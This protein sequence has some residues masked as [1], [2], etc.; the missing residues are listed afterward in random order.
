MRAIKILHLILLIA[1]LAACKV[2]FNYQ[3]APEVPEEAIVVSDQV[4]D[5]I[6]NRDVESTLS[7]TDMELMEA[8]GV[9]FGKTLEVLF[10]LLPD[11]ENAI[12]TQAYTEVRKNEDPKNPYPIYLVKYEHQ[13]DKRIYDLSIYVHD[14]D[15]CCLLRHIS[16]NQSVKKD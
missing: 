7:I 2:N 5:A 14:R 1:M 16:F 15:Q 6:L 3:A 9:E 8:A 10:S 13:K 4:R 12:F 11:E